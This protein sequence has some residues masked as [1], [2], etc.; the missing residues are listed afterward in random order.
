[1][2]LKILIFRKLN[3]IKGVTALFIFFSVL[4]VH[5]EVNTISPKVNNQD[6]TITGTVVD[7]AGEPLPGANV[8]EKGTTNGTTTDFD[9]K[10]SLTVSDPNAI[11]I[12][13][14]VG[15]SAQEVGINGKESLIVKLEESN[16]LDE[17][18]VVGYGK[19][20]RS[21]VTGAVASIST[22]ALKELP[23]ARV[24]QALQ[25]RIAG[26]DVQNNDAAPNG[27]T[28]IRIR[29]ANSIN[30]G[31]DPLVVIDG[32][33]GGA[34]NQVNPNDV[35]S[36]EV[37]KDASA[38]AVYGSR[39]ANGVVLITTKEGGTNIS[40]P[41][42]AYSS[43]LK[44]HN[45]AEKLSLMNAGQYAET[46]NAHR[47]ATG[48][49]EVFSASEIAGFK[50]DGGTDW[51]DQIFKTGY[52]QNHQL[53]VSGANENVSYYVSG[54]IVDQKGIV[55]GSSY[56]RYALRPNLNIK[57]NEKL[58]VDVKAYLS[59][60]IDNPTIQN[61]FGGSSIY[62]AQVWAPVKSVYDADG[63][64]T[65]PGGGYGPTINLNPVGQALEPVSD[66][67]D[68]T[69]SINSSII[70]KITDD[71]TLNI[72]GGYRLNDYERNSF[73]NA[74][75][76]QN[77][78][79]ET[80][81]IVNGRSMTLQNTNIL[82]YQKTFA[83][84]YDLTVTGVVEQQFEEFNNS[85]ISVQ[86]PLL[87][88]GTFN[89]VGV[90][91]EF[92]P[93]SSSRGKRTLLSYVGRVNYGYDS[94]YLVTLTARSDGSSVFGKNN[95]RAFFP[96]VGLGWNVSNENF[97][98]DNETLTNL[99]LRASWGQVGNQ[100]IGP[101]G[102]L[103]RLNA[104]GLAAFPIDG[105][106]TSTGVN[107]DSRAPNP[108]LKW[109]TTTQTN[110]GLEADFLNGRIQTTVE[111]Y[112]KQTEDLLQVAGLPNTS[113]RTSILRNIG[114]VENKG[115]EIYIGATPVQGDNFRW[116][117]GVT[118]T[119]NRNKVVDLGEVTELVVGG[120]G[121]PGF[122]NSIWLEEGQPLGLFRGYQYAGVWSTSEATEAATFS[123]GG[124]PFF[125][126]APKFVDQNGDNIIDAKDIVNIGNAQAD[127]SFGWTNSFS[128]KNFDLNVF[129]QGVQ[130]KENFNV[131]RLRVETTSNDSD[132][133]ST[134]ILNRWSATN[135]NTDVP[136]FEGFNA[137]PIRNSSRWVEDASYIR[138]KNI[139]L[140][141][142]LSNDA[143]SKLG[144]DSAKIYFTGTNLFTFTDY[145]G[146]DP[147][148]STGVDRF[149]GIDLASF[150]SQKIYTLGL[151]IK[152]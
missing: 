41:T 28:T 135:D 65:L 120:A 29:G 142:N 43:F 86:G 42:V 36:I 139:T 13:S 131:A 56:N 125:P 83:E 130:G 78:G 141:Y 61:S 111:Y 119:K 40:K 136:S 150:P 100:A 80:A 9:G 45:V 18:V 104:G 96:S 51:Q 106:N 11:L 60:E 107:I 72:M 38:T 48:G 7:G 25:G 95:K 152:F 15:F 102:S 81:G 57:V 99:K 137:F 4:S 128:Y 147:E 34:L 67:F 110:I 33:V 5:A 14:F 109:E 70:Y 10:F 93:S 59:K 146:Y 124:T 114:K 101:Y 71:L 112:N 64:Y 31:N 103:S 66:F 88:S 17:V 105:L 23:V 76:A 138:V 82:T 79:E 16:T 144:I 73:N 44:V 108:D 113:A 122:D 118:Y 121:V 37:L 6:H 69:T 35:K 117:T 145:T 74:K 24:D 85:S 27:K 84:K 77:Y 97:L 3:V 123:S 126:G 127:Y 149:A 68:N 26:V 98:K 133:T 22:K 89:N 94:K 2:K 32:F 92:F 19:Q 90:A 143:T 63:N 116:N 1:M 151:D 47:L 62:S 30:G 87:N 140:G 58:S 49:S 52:S 75:V 54:E 20:K 91:S 21:D 39:G 134:R 53:S 8:I 148:A 55:L 46:V 132:A 115:I 50:A 12:V 129:I